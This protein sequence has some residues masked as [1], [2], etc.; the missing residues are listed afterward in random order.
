M[1]QKI[2]LIV[3]S[4]LIL[5]GLYSQLSN[6]VGYADAAEAMMEGEV[7]VSSLI[8]R[9]EPSEGAESLGGYHQGD[10]VTIYGTSGDWYQV[11]HSSGWGYVHS[12]YINVINGSASAET[13]IGKVSVDNLH[14]RDSASIEGQI[15]SHLSRGT[16][17]ELGTFSNGWYQVSIG[18]TRGYIDGSYIELQDDSSNKGGSVPDSTSNEAEPL[19]SGKV[20]AT[21]LNVRSSASTEADII[22]SLSR[23][24]TIELLSESNGWYEVETEKGNGYIHGSYVSTTSLSSSGNTADGQL[25]GKTIFVDA[26][27]GGSDPGAIVDDISEK[28][29]ALD[30]SLKLQNALEN[31]GAT[32][33]MSRTEDSYIEVGE[34]ADMANTSGADLFIS[35]HANAFTSSSVNGS[36]VFY[37]SQT[38]ADNSRQFAQAIQSQLVNGLNRADRGVVDRNL[39]VITELDMPGILIEPGFMSN[40][41]DLDMLLNQQDELVAHIVKGF[42]DYSN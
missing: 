1:V 28:D 5:V 35:V 6:N 30:V 9:E 29:I 15:I 39:T 17:I 40:D 36:E 2:S 38:H 10:K 16:L 25:E 11:K 22:D 18:T 19:G 3:L 14:V 33:V 24:T 12:A 4:L 37:S 7:A 34:R 21:S 13:K 20:T 41:S 8:I 26:G 42:K 27:H 32:V 23:G 31:E